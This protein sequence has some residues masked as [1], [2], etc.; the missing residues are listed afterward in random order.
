MSADARRPESAAALSLRRR[1][2]LLVAVGA[3]LLLAAAAGAFL[4][5]HGIDPISSNRVSPA[6]ESLAA[7]A[8]PASAF[9]SRYPFLAE[10]QRVE[11]TRFDRLDQAVRLGFRRGATDAE[12]DRVV[13]QAA[14]DVERERLADVDDGAALR[15]MVELR[16]AARAFKSSD[17]AQCV[18][19]LR[20]HSPA[21][22]VRSAAALAAISPALAG[23]LDA[24]AG[25]RRQTPGPQPQGPDVS[26]K[27]ACDR[28]LLLYDTAVASSPDAGADF[29]RALQGD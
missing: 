9:E 15:L 21:A 25:P 8:P 2:R 23:L 22:P 29:I 24:P 12:L 17:P 28:L 18:A 11:P 13:A 14:D 5:W 27:L 6:D 26:A 20:P 19:I 10:L 7:F 16:T 1:V 3:L 4:T